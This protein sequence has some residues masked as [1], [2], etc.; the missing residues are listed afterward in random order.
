MSGT[1]RHERSAGAI[2]PA[3]MPRSSA[4]SAFTAARR[5]TA[6]QPAMPDPFGRLM[7]RSAVAFGPAA[8]RIATLIGALVRQE[9]RHRLA[10]KDLPD[11][12]PDQRADVRHA[13]LAGQRT[14]EA[15]D[16]QQT[17][18][19][20]S[21]SRLDRFARLLQALERARIADDARDGCGAV[22]GAG[23]IRL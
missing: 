5:L 13:R 6:T 3:R 2:S 19:H 21:A 8:K 7:P 12:H 10:R 20:L 23:M 15:G 22:S 9:D 11:D 16:R 18:G 14:R 17:V 4:A 1:A